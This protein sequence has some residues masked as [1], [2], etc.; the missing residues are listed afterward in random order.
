MKASISFHELQQIIADKV[1]LGDMKIAECTFSKIDSQTVHANL[2]IGLLPSHLDLKIEEI[3]GTDLHLSYSGGFGI[4]PLVN[5]LLFYVKNNPDL[6][7]VEKRGNS[8]LIV[9]LSQI[10]KVKPVIDKFDVRTVSVISDA[11]EVDGTLKI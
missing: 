5:T 9:H 7:F 4:Q 2:K 10:E 8:N 6:A 1:K 11:L 3:S